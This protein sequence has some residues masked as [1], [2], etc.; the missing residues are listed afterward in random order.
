MKIGELQAAG[1][2]KAHSL[3]LVHSTSQ[4]AIKQGHRQLSEKG[5]IALAVRRNMTA[6]SCAGLSVVLLGN[7]SRQTVARA[8]VRT[9]R[10]LSLAAH[11]FFADEAEACNNQDNM[12]VSILSL[13]SDA[14]NSNVLQKTQ[15]LNASNIV[16]L[17]RQFA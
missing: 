9:A 6:I 2:S 16:R 10:V 11:H 13:R 8:E 5:L 15:A 17:G 14:T 4:R 7:V 1:T 12:S 3:D